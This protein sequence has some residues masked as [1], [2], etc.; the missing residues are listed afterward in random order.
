MQNLNNINYTLVTGATSGIGY[1][2][3]KQAAMDGCNLI[4]VAR[5]EAEL[6]KVSRDF[7]VYDVDVKTIAR[8]LSESGAAMDVYNETKRMNTTV[9]ML[10]NNAGQGQYGKFAES[11]IERQLE[12]IRLNIDTLVCLTHCFLNDML[13]RNE[14]RILQLGSEVS[15]A[16]MPL[17]AVYGATKAFVLSFTEALINEL[18]DSDVSITL[19]MPGATDTDFFNKAEMTESK[20]Y[21][22]AEMDSPVELAEIAYKALKK[23]DRRIIGPAGKKNVLVANLSPDNMVANNMRK[24]MEPSEKDRDETRQRSSHEQSRR[25]GEPHT[26][27]DDR[28]YN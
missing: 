27:Y 2:L 22:E 9:N 24:N 20:V 8:D 3:A 7:H 12:I 5:D 21:R 15:K 4:L 26:Q 11:D 16:P 14:G 10:I 28:L 18:D 6:Q 1:E 19:L 23:G 25:A 13:E 17:A